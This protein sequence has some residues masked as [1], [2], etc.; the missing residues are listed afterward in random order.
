MIF[1]II[2]DYRRNDFVLQPDC[3]DVMVFSFFRGR[4]I[5]AAGCESTSEIHMD[6]PADHCNLRTLLL[7]PFFFHA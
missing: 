2:I 3:G 1:Q 4:I 5:N 6:L 7:L